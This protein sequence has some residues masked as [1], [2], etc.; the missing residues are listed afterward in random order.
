MTLLITVLSLIALVSVWTG[1]K[2]YVR[3]DMLNQRRVVNA[4]L[5]LMLFIT[6]LTVISWLDV[7]TQQLAASLTAGLFVFAGGFFLGYAIKLYFF[8]RRAGKVLYMNSSVL[9]TYAPALISV[10]LVAFGIYRTEVLTLGPFTLV[11]VT[12]GLSLIA[13]GMWGWVINIVPEFREKGLLLLDQYIS[14]ER[15]ISFE[16]IEE[17]TL[18]M[19]YMTPGP[20]VSSFRT[21]VPAEDRMLLERIL[22]EQMDQHHEERKEVLAQDDEM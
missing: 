10:I 1:Y 18:E 22:A 20:H 15:L 9:T 6:A 17:T 19:D 4:F 13:F 12:S 16:W 11:G 3:L 7:L 2:G 8:K 5:I 21:Y 14:W